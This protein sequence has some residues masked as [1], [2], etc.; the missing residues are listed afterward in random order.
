MKQLAY[1]QSILSVWQDSNAGTLSLA[2]SSE[3]SSLNE[4][5]RASERLRCGVFHCLFAV[6]LCLGEYVVDVAT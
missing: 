3:V 5:V 2:P 1:V 4:S 6:R